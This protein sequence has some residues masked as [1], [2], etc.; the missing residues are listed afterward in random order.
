MTGG[1]F[2]RPRANPLASLR[3]LCFPYA[4]GGTSV[5]HDWTEGL[6]NNVEVISVLLPGRGP[7]LK[8]KP[9]ISIM[10]IVDALLE[11]I[12][13]LDSKPIAL[14]GHSYGG[15]L[16]FEL[17]RALEKVNHPP[18]FTALSA[19]RAAHLP[20]PKSP[21]HDLPPEDFIR[22]LKALEG[23]PPEIIAHHDLLH[24]ALPSLRADFEALET[25]AYS[26]GAKLASPLYVFGGL[27][28]S[29]VSRPELETWEQLTTGYFKLQMLVDRH[30]YLESSRGALLRMISEIVRNRIN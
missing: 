12:Q 19:C 18:I 26:E 21:I 20:N 28:D 25:Y 8:E 14:F 7:R 16:A 1:W 2:V 23:T 17:A 15:L 3:L 30:H 5:Y 29:I 22:E 27:Q 13:T 24:A 11:Q 6:P 9:L 10:G 4:G